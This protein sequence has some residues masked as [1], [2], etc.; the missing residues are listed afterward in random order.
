MP[1]T[2]PIGRLD[3]FVTAKPLTRESFAAFGDVIANPRP[4]VVPSPSAALPSLRLPFQAV[5]ANQGSAIKYQ[6]VTRPLNLY[7]QAPSRVR[8]V[9]IASMFVC[10]AGRLEDREA[11][12]PGGRGRGGGAVARGEGLSANASASLAGV[13]ARAVGAE[14]GREAGYFVVEILERHPFTTQT[15]VPLTTAPEGTYLVIVAPSLPSSAADQSLP[16]P[17]VADGATLPGRGLPD[18]QRL[19]AFIATAGQA[20]TYGAGTWHAPMVALGREGTALDFVV[21]QAANGVAIE[22]CQEV[23]FVS[24]EAP[25]PRVMVEVPSGSRLSKL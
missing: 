24:E 5:T 6:H 11:V 10:A 17:K 18:L 8:A 15:F 25:R 22:D 23:V 1:V 13:P 19:Q 3:V 9:G 21:F 16:V 4:D 12:L 20:V 7:D 2:I 14:T